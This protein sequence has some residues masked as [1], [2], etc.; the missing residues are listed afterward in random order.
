MIQAY[1]DSEA[2]LL[3]VLCHSGFWKNSSNQHSS[4]IA[5]LPLIVTQRSI[6]QPMNDLS[7]L[8]LQHSNFTH[9]FVEDLMLQDC[10]YFRRTSHDF[11]THTHPRSILK[12][13]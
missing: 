12:H 6:L 8:S 10:L 2:S 9:S 5:G 1:D 4:D 11:F 3:L 7:S 13:C